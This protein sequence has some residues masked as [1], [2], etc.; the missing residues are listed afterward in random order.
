MTKIISI[1]INKVF[2]DPKTIENG[3]MFVKSLPRDLGALFCMPETKIHRFWMKNTFVSLDMIFLDANFNVVG[4]VENT[5]PH[6][7]S[8][9]YVNHPSKYVIEI[10]S[11]FVKRRDIKVD[12]IINPIYLKKST[13]RT[14]RR[15]RFKRSITRKHL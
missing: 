15:R 7:L 14:R 10:K 2:K 9:H 5:I 12:D 3:L 8:P 13:S 4:F 11:G 1:K 6:D